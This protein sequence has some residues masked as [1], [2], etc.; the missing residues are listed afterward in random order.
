MKTNCILDGDCVVVMNDL[1]AQSVDLVFADPPY[2][3]QLGNVLRRPDNSCV[4]SVD[5]LWD[6]FRS[7]SEYDHFTRTWIQA[8]RRILKSDGGLW[9]MGSYHNIY[10]VGAILQDEGFWILNDIIWHKTNPMPNFRGTRFTNSHETLLWCATGPEARYTFNY[11]AM[12]AMNEG[13]QMRSDWHLPLCTGGERLRDENGAKIHPTQ[14]PEALLYRVILSST[15][16]G[17]IILDPFF[18]TG[19]SGVV[20]KRLG[21][22]YIGIERDH[23]YI[24][25]ALRRLA[26]VCETENHRIAIVT[27]RKRA[28]PRVLFSAVVERGL[29]PPGTVLFDVARRFTAYVRA[30]GT[31]IS[32]DHRGSI[33]QVG[34][35]VQGVSACNGWTFWYFEAAG[36]LMSI[37]VLRQQVRKV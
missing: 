11:E 12:K 15:E 31:I 8:V 32:S 34:A 1:P 22:R 19:T 10:R 13:V 36:Q 23:T 20:A 35:A 14:K 6:R 3:L 9:I 27:P 28:E 25:V 21:R 18:G 7:F 17:D 37:D 2:N 26:G 4:K 30:D 16:P 29:L 24:A 5:V 33:H